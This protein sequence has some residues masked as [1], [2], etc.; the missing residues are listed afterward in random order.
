MHCGHT[1]I[2]HNDTLGLFVI[3]LCFGYL[4]QMWALICGF[5]YR[6][7]LALFDGSRLHNL[8]FMVSFNFAVFWSQLLEGYVGKEEADISNLRMGIMY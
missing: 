8:S 4:D 6:A 7:F 1:Y 3:Y 5:E 2:T